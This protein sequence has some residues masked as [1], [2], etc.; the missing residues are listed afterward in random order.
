MSTMD[1]TVVQKNF[2]DKHG[3][4]AQSL[5]VN[6]RAQKLGRIYLLTRQEAYT[7]EHP[8]CCVGRAAG[9]GKPLL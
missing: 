1:R 8:S 6:S 7:P 5:P 2:V 3:Y 9:S 4:L